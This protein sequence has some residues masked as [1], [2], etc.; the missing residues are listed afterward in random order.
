MQTVQTV[1]HVSTH[2][3]E[4]ESLDEASD[5]VVAKMASAGT[6]VVV[7]QVREVVEKEYYVT[8]EKHATSYKRVKVVAE[9]VVE[10]RKRAMEQAEAAEG[11]WAGGQTADA[12]YDTGDVEQKF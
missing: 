6:P 1:R 11:I 4:A 9:N 7:T 8:V 12:S 3:V 5:K 10:A 2:D